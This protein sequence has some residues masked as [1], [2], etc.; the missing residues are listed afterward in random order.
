MDRNKT[1]E[2]CIREEFLI[3]TQNYP[4]EYHRLFSDKFNRAKRRYNEQPATSEPKGIEPI[5]DQELEN[6]L[7]SS[8]FDDDYNILYRWECETVDKCVLIAKQYAAS[9]TKDL[10]KDLDL[11][12]AEINKLQMNQITQ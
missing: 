8:I 11:A 5:K 3:N 9:K 6:K 10:Q 7:A 12:M 1:F 4:K 2:E